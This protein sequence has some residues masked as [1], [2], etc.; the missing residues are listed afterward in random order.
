MRIAVLAPELKSAYGWASYA[1]DMAN[2]LSRQGIEVVALTQPGTSCVAPSA[3]LADW[4]PVLPPLIPP[5]RWFTLHS[6][7]QVARVRQ[8][9]ADCDLLHIMAEPYALVAWLAAGKRPTVITAHGT[10]VP[11]MVRR[12]G[13]GRFYRAIFARSHLIAVSEYTASQVRAALPGVEAT[14]IRNGV[15]FAKF[16]VPQ[17]PPVKHG[18]TILASGGVKERKGTHLL[19]EA[20]PRVRAVIPNVQL[21][22]TGGQGD[23]TYL[24]QVRQRIDQL[25]LES[26]VHLVGMISEN[27]LLA[28]YQHADV[29]AVPSLAVGDKFEG[30]GLVFLEASACGLPVIGT[31]G[32]GIEEAILDGQTGLL[33]PQ[34]DVPALADAL[35]RL[36]Q[37][38]DL[39]ARLCATG[40]EYARTQ[41]WIAV[42]GRVADYYRQ[43]LP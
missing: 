2:A 18:P 24:A 20:L 23:A 10:Y 21:V 35:L 8:A 43:L 6:M 29:F 30:F 32:S 9:I 13:L 7:M 37:E 26:C 28:W 34:N 16:Q 36:L 4:R 42:A 17:P 11:L 15:H 39:R 38:A 41:D 14:V 40:R 5:V 19:I 27:D 31:T 1:L 25:G 33:I 22:V 12:H 3:A